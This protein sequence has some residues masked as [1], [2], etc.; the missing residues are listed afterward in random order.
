MLFSASLKENYLFRRL[1]RRGT[2]SANAHFVI[3][4]R[5]NGTARNRVGLTVSG[6]L[7]GAVQR[8]KLRRRLREIYRLHESEFAAGWDF[9]IVA[10][11]RAMTAPYAV[12]EREYL[13]LARRA[14]LCRSEEAQS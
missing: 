1:Y 10:R 9:I 8:N 5:P 11:T 12:L 14:G 3:Y 6:K 4:C 13:A 7:G 2:S